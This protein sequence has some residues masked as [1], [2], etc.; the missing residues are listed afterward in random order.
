MK[1]LHVLLA[2]FS[3]VAALYTDNGAVFKLTSKNFDNEVIR[4]DD[5]WLV[6]FYAPWC[7]HC[8]SLAPEWEK[9]AK[10]LKGIV[11][12]GAVDM[13]TDQQVGSP[14]NVQ[15][16]P[17]LKFFGDA[18]RSPIDYNGGRNAKDITEFALEQAKAIVSKRLGGKKTTSSSSSGGS[19]GGHKEEPA[20][21]KDVIVLTDSNF[22]EIVFGSKDMWL[23]EFYAP[24]CGHCKSL[25][26]EWNK[27]A[28]KLKGQ[29][30]VAKV[31]A[32][33]ETSLAQ[34]FGV[35]GYPTIKIFPAGEKSGKAEDYNGPR[36]AEGIVAAALAKLEQYGIAPEIRQLTSPQVFKDQCEGSN[37]CVLAFL[38]HIL[39]S[40][41]AER[42]RY[43]DV[44]AQSAK[45]NRSKPFTFIWAQGGDHYKFEEKLGLSFGYPAVLAI[46]TTRQMYSIMRSAYTSQELDFF[47]SSLTSGT[48]SLTP[49]T[50]LPQL[51]AVAEWDGKDAE[52]EREEL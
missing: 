2:S 43:I 41:A 20:T 7:G 40:S 30:K 47:V 3:L 14:Y 13:T 36:E 16:F 18:K 37:I 50:D 29:V 34:R 51:K 8:K 1:M 52:P 5:I 6:E 21:E 23:V 15:G 9:A 10:A 25:A 42:T 39:D 48:A 11:K 19:S 27:A 45:K 31:D 46:S 33:V 38:P 35:K 28:T 17:T 12:V 22:D 24:W 4:S 26:P 32:T 44:I 49:Y